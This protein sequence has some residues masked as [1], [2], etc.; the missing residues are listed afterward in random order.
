MY[1]QLY[2]YIYILFQILFHY[3]LLQGIEY[4]SRPILRSNIITSTKKKW[5]GQNKGWGEV[6]FKL[7]E[8]PGMKV[9]IEMSGS[10]I[11]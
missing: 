11:L 2:I 4:S 6:K 10:L 1:I 8:K 7:K 3:R 9:S 5:Q